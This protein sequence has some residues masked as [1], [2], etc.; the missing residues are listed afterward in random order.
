LYVKALVQELES[1][2]IHVDTRGDSLNPHHLEDSHPALPESGSSDEAERERESRLRAI[3]GLGD[4][5]G[6]GEVGIFKISH[7]GKRFVDIRTWGDRGSDI[8]FHF[9]RRTSIFRGNDRT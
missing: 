1:H 2:H 7:L 5:E 4:A 3:D 6:N 8:R 9:A